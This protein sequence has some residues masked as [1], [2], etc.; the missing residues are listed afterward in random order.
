MVQELCPPV[1]ETE[2]IN[3]NSQPWTRHHLGRIIVTVAMGPQPTKR[4][5]IT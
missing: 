4:N 3:I 1:E 5:Y 2:A